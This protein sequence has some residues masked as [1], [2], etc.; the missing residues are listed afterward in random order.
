MQNKYEPMLP[1]L[2]EFAARHPGV[3]RA[4]VM[5]LAALGYGLLLGLVVVLVA[6]EVFLGIVMIR[7]GAFQILKLA[8]PL[9]VFIGILV[10]SLWIEVLPPKG[11]EL[12]RNEAPA[13]WAEIDRVRRELRAPAPYKVLIDRQVNASVQQVPR[14]GVLGFYRT[15]LTIGLPLAASVT[16]AEFRALL[17]HEFGHVSRKHGRLGMW[18]YRVQATWSEVLEELEQSD[19]WSRGAFRAFLRWYAPYFDAYTAVLRRAHEFEADR[20][21]AAVAG[22]EAAVTLLCRLAVADRYQDD[23]FWPAVQ[24]YVAKGPNAPAGVFRQLLLD[25]PKAAE[26][27]EARIWLSDAAARRTRPWDTHPSLSERLASLGAAPAVPAAPAQPSAAEVL[28][29]THLE[30]VADRLSRKWTDDVQFTWHKLYKE[31]LALSERLS[32]LDQRAG[33]QPL[34]PVEERERILLTVKVKGETVA[35]PLVRDFVAAGQS[36]GQIHFLWGRNL[37]RDGDEEGLRHLERAMEMDVDLVPA[38]CALAAGHLETHGR[39]AEAA[40]FR[41]RSDAHLEAVQQAHAERS[42][43]TLSATDTFLPHGLDA[44][45]V[46]EIAR[47]F[48]DEPD[49]SRALLVRKEVTALADLPCFVLALSFRPAKGTRQPRALTVSHLVSLVQVRG[50]LTIVELH[51]SGLSFSLERVPGAEVYNAAALAPAGAR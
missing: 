10:E 22:N 9:L 36:D 13:L 18:I 43:E 31:H 44:D 11:I 5:A 25:A 23:V 1:R 15:Y 24:A 48:A 29:G 4:R 20:A 32:A 47:R 39:P 49:V 42:A 35:M 12:G 30:R 26:H 16:P 51:S 50:T 34:P 19:H 37:L 6:L 33:A 38:A 3:Y 2:A 40:A 21:A 41:A 8:I 7:T 45:H 17:A 28:F 46:R 27:H 14:L